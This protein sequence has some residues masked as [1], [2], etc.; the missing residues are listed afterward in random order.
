M[1]LRELFRHRY[2]K[3]LTGESASGEALF[4]LVCRRGGKTLKAKTERTRLR[5]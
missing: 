4:D 5:Q 2:D 1:G 3:I